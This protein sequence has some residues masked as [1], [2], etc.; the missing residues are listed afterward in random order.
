MNKRFLASLLV[1]LFLTVGGAQ[2]QMAS[3]KGVTMDELLKHLN[4]LVQKG[5]DESKAE[6]V[7]EADAMAKSKDESFVSMAV[8]VYNTIDEEAK[9]EVLEKNIVKRFPKGVKA[10]SEA[11]NA[12]K[13]KEG[14]SAEIFE[15]EYNAWLKKFPSKSFGEK[16]QSVYDM[17]ISDLAVRYSEEGNQ[18]KANALLESLEGKPGYAAGMY[19]VAKELSDK[20]KYDESLPILEK[21][22]KITQEAVKNP[23]EGNNG[24]YA[25]YDNV[26][27]GLFGNAL[28]K[29]NKINEAV[30][31]LEEV[32]KSRPSASATINLADALYAQNKKLDAFILLNDFIV[33][34]GKSEELVAAIQPKYNELN[35]GN[36][37]FDKYVAA[38]DVKVKEALVAKYKSE[39]VKEEAPDFELMDRDG[40]LVKLSDLKGKMVVLDFW[41]TWCG[42]CIISFP[43]MQAAVDK[44]RDD[45]EVEF[46][47]VNTWQNEPNYKELV[48]KFITE[49]NYRFTVL[50]DEMKDRSKAAVTAYGVRGIPTKV[51][52]DKEGFIRFQS[53][54]GSDN[55]EKIV[56]EMETKIELM[57]EG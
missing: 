45:E 15:K 17:A 30:E 25:R 19:S 33:A 56:N 3:K 9:A 49:N 37:D 32:A 35:N 5:D 42:P 48:E 40:N 54:G 10:R 14:V 11:Y 55:V 41:A 4:T 21:A 26:I 39:M 6:L 18:A 36:G 57:R 31:V 43:G 1:G 12:I 52:I 7:K 29:A 46:L 27:G 16:E 24:M 2:A 44:Y 8:R 20:E 50:F 28:L 34:N 51:F 22:Y 23:G 53:A 47:F 13:Q 38:L